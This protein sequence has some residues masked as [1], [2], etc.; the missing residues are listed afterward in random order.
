MSVFMKYAGLTFFWLAT[1]IVFMSPVGATPAKSGASRTI[2]FNVRNMTC[3]G[4]SQGLAQSLRKLPGVSG[5][6]VSLPAHQAT[7]LYN[8]KSTSVPKLKAFF[9]QAGFPAEVA[10]G[11]PPKT[12][13]GHG[14]ASGQG[15]P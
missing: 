8:A 3:A 2:T 13:N 1:L 12:T 7:V 4:C 11:R 15:T 10:D 9:A 6:T 5:A 14:K